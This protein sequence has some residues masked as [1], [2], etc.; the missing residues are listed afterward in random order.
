MQEITVNL[1]EGGIMMEM[2]GTYSETC[3]MDRLWY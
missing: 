1:R 2:D 3:P